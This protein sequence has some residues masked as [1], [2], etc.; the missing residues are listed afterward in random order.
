M[1]HTKQ[2]KC[3]QLRFDFLDEEEQRENLA[4]ANNLGVLDM[5]R[6]GGLLHHNTTR[7]S[8]ISL[9][10]PLQGTQQRSGSHDAGSSR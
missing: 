5:S 7:N 2:N 10:A 6:G 8:I 3:S 4:A 9:Q 1:T